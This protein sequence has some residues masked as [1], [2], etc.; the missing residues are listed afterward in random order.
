MAAADARPR[1]PTPRS[2]LVVGDPISTDLPPLRFA[3]A[4]IDA[5]AALFPGDATETHRGAA[6]TAAAYEASAP[7]RFSMIHFAAHA[8]VTAASPLESSIELTPAAG[9]HKLYARD[10]AGRP[11]RANLVTISA[12][13]GAG[14]R[15]YSGEG[16]VGFAWAFLRAGA[17]QVI[18][19]LWDVDDQ[20]TARLMATLYR[21]LAAGDAPAAALRHAKLDLI[22]SGGNFAKPY[23]WAPFQLFRAAR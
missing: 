7:E 4:E 3:G 15:A 11:L 1:A 20:S 12:C 23:Y 19:G 5:I 17:R 10:V 18:A 8:T 22:R 9:R 21:R 6:A 14:A 13:R 2:L 16:L